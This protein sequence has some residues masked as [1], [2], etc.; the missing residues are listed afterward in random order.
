MVLEKTLESR[1]DCREIKLVSP[2][3][4]QSWIFIGGPMLKLRFQYFG[5]LMQRAGS[6][7]KTLKLGKTEGRRTR[8]HQRRGWCDG[9]ISSMDMLLLLLSR[10][11]RV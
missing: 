3:G 6:L 9:I 11:S 1:L 4:N 8:G 5:H 7:E 2:K 10:F